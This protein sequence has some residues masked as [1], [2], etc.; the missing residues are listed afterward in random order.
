MEIFINTLM[1]GIQTFLKKE[2]QYLLSRFQNHS[3]SLK[4]A[5]SILSDCSFHKPIIG[6]ITVIRLHAARCTFFKKFIYFI[7]LFIYFW[8]HWIFV[9]AHGLFSGCG[10]WGLLFIAVHGLLIVMASLAVEHGL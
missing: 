7:I 4:T 3:D 10:G 6:E 1:L 5:S 2:N 8:L 9:A